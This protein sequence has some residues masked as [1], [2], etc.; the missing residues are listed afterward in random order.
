MPDGGCSRSFFVDFGHGATEHLTDPELRRGG[1]IRSKRA[2]CRSKAAAIPRS[3]RGPFSRRSYLNAKPGSP[4]RPILGSKLLIL[5]STDRCRVPVRI[6]AGSVR[7]REETRTSRCGRPP[8][9]QHDGLE[10]AGFRIP[11]ATLRRIMGNFLQSARGGER[12]VVS[13]SRVERPCPNSLEVDRIDGDQCCRRGNLADDCTD[14]AAR[15]FA[16]PG[17]DAGCR[18]G[19]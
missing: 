3:Q 6:P 14:L 17:V 13:R 8:V 2:G 15:L 16:D 9:G 12:V 5:C 19:I 11:E 1:L 7:V 10:F 4:I 18:S